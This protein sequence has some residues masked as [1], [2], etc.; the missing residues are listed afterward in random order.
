MKFEYTGLSC[1][2]RTDVICQTLLKHMLSYGEKFK[3]SCAICSKSFQVRYEYVEHMH[4]HANSKRFQCSVC[5]M[6]FVAKSDAK[7]HTICRRVHVTETPA[8]TT[9]PSAA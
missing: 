8:V 4:R 7:Q 2:T 5:G 6:N 1:V 3:Y 9:Q